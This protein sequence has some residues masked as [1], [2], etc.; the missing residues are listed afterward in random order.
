[1]GRQQLLVKDKLCNLKKIIK[2]ISSLIYCKIS[3]QHTPTQATLILK[4]QNETINDKFQHLFPG[5][6]NFIASISE[7]GF[8]SRPDINLFNLAIAKPGCNP[9][10][11]AR[12]QFKIV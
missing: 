12:V 10:G 8:L 3:K 6:E 4:P 7:G 1:M 5:S 9:L 11:Q 2:K